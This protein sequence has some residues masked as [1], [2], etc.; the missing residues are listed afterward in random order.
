MLGI[1]RSH[2]HPF[3][4]YDWQLNNTSLFLLLLCHSFIC[5]LFS[6]TPTSYRKLRN[7]WA[8]SRPFCP[9]TPMACAR[10]HQHKHTYVQLQAQGINEHIGT[11]TWIHRDSVKQ[12]DP[13]RCSPTN[14]HKYSRQRDVCRFREANICGLIWGGKL[15]LWLRADLYQINI[16]Q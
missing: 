5:A 6:K 2:V 16:G 7:E 10:A 3:Q 4:A 12:R 14:M 8:N 9:L 13:R 11:A 1:G 15:A